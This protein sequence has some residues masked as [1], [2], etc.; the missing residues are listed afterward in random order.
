MGFRARKSIG[1]GSGVRLNVSKKGIGM[2]AGA[3]GVRYSAHS[4]GRRTVSARTGIPGVTYQKSAQSRNSRRTVARPAPAP[5]ASPKPGIFAQ[6]G[7]KQLFKAI[8][9]DDVAAIKRV[10]EDHPDLRIGAWSL[11]GLQLIADDPRGSDAT[12]RCGLPSWG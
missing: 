12:P 2:S 3:G 9:A 11:A 8:R 1:L 10:G 6:K 7:E 4:S 5:S